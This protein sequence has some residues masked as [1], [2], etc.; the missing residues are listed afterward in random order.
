MARY[1]RYIKGLKAS[2]SMEVEVMFGVVQRDIRTVTGSNIAL[3]RQE[4]GLDPNFTFPW[5]LKV[6]LLENTADLNK[7]SGLELMTRRSS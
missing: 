4:T 3:I 2:P 7:G 5:K 1:T 6:K